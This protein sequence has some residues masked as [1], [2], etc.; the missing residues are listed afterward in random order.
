MS[1]W[2]T[3]PSAR[4]A[5]EVAKT[6]AVWRE[7]GYQIALQRDVRPAGQCLSDQEALG[8]DKV[9]YT[10]Y[11]GYSRGVNRMVEF[12]M[13]RD[14]HA[15]WFI[16][17]G[18]DTLPDPHRIAADTARECR[19]YF[20][21]PIVPDDIPPIYSLPPEMETYG[22]MQPTG[23]RWGD[24]PIN[25]QRF[26]QDRGAYIDRVAGSAWI[27]REFIRRTYG[28]RGPMWPEYFHMFNDEELQLVAEKLGVFWQRRDLTHMHNH[29]QREAHPGASVGQ[30]PEFLERAYSRANWDA[31]RGIFEARKEAGFPGAFMEGGKTDVRKDG[32]GGAAW[33]DGFAS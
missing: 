11:D 21:R 20:R 23:D 4:P 5:V 6:M 8:V 33:G 27:G 22:V 7:R 2:L 1:V 13:D 28:G 24:T 14:P 18:D 25:R 3:I 12:V 19:H 29:C 30:P 15:E 32:I 16:C 17:A 10:E 31:M 9:L 26:G